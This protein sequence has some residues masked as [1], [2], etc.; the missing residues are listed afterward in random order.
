MVRIVP[1]ANIED[2][3]FDFLIETT[4]ATLTS[5]PPIRAVDTF[6][7]FVPFHGLRW[8][9]NDWF[10]NPSAHCRRAV[11]N[12]TR[13]PDNPLRGED[14]WDYDEYFE[15]ACNLNRHLEELVWVFQDPE[16]DTCD[17]DFYNIQVTIARELAEGSAKV[18]IVGLEVVFS[19]DTAEERN[20]RF[21]ALCEAAWEPDWPDKEAKMARLEFHTLEEYR[22]LVGPEQAALEMSPY[23][24]AV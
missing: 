24:A 10:P 18:I 22:A 23:P 15:D 5:G 12:I 11:I 2:E 13:F 17:E 9:G 4:V 3:D 1:D 19:N 14:I 20:N 8:S 7:S 6:V 21:R 16:A